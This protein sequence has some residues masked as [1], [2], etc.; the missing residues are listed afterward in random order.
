MKTIKTIKLI[1]AAIFLFALSFGLQAQDNPP[2]PPDHG[3]TGDQDPGGNAPLSG[4]TIIL[5]GLGLAYG[6][7][8]V[9]ELRTKKEEELV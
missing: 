9:Y 7:K 3:E 2:D 6:G 1:I 4:G 5:L 8:R